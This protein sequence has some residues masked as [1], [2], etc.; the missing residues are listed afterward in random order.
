MGGNNLVDN[1]SSRALVLRPAGRLGL[2]PAG[3][4]RGLDVSDEFL[5]SC[6]VQGFGIAADLHLRIARD[7]R[8]DPAIAD[9]S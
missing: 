8:R 3:N 5:S 4:Q 1:D 9:R 6:R 7:V 2:W